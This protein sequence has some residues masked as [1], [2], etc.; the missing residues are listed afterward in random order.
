MSE[1][2]ENA[3]HNFIDTD[4]VFRVLLFSDQQS[5]TEQIVDSFS[6]NRPTVS[7]LVTME[8]ACFEGGQDTCSKSSITFFH[9]Q[10][11]QQAKRSIWG[12]SDRA[13][14]A[15]CDSLTAAKVGFSGEWSKIY[16]H[17]FQP[18]LELQEHGK[19]RQV[20][21]HTAAL[22]AV[23]HTCGIH[24]MFMTEVDDWILISHSTFT[25]CTAL[26]RQPNTPGNGTLL[27]KM[28]WCQTWRTDTPSPLCSTLNF[29]SFCHTLWYM[30]EKTGS[31]L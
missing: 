25:R 19:K 20:Y 15:T 10:T 2:S 1:K 12:E 13:T 27:V 24:K 30:M 26:R 22:Q 6:F 11:H 7:T 5:K 28:T 8:K 16:G 4:D 18:S 3:H 23:R 14:E 21:E 9:T 29:Y 17:T 31:F